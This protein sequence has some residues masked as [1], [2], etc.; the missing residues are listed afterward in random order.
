MSGGLQMM[1]EHGPELLDDRRHRH[2]APASTV[3]WPAARS[4]CCRPKWRALQR[5]PATARLVSIC[6]GAFALAAVGRLDGRPATTHWGWSDLFRSLY[7][8]VDLN[9]DV[10]FVDDGDVLDV[11]RGRRRDRPVPAHRPA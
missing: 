1:P 8:S 7:P 9:P 10:L 5:I 2:R 11:G 4:A 6:T 3:G